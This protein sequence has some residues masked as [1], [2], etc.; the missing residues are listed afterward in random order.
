VINLAFMVLKF[1]IYLYSHLNLFFADTIDSFVDSFVIFLIIIFLR[2][3]LNGTLTF[4]NMD[5]MI[6]SQWCTILVFRII[7]FLEQI[8]DLIKPEPREQP[9]LIIIISCI[10]I[11]GSI[12]I[13]ILFV[14]EDDVVKFFISKEEKKLKKKLKRKRG[15]VKKEKKGCKILPIFAETIDNFVTTVISLVIGI[16]LYFKVIENYLYLIDDISNM[17]I[18][19][20]MLIIAC[21]SLW[22]ISKK[23]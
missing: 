5:M 16:L 13:A 18:S 4:L 7:I 2:F 23:V 15:D 14:D 19:I 17:V 8:S 20:V 11:A 10:V 22:K 1:I 6:F 12:V 9:L 3:N 21:R